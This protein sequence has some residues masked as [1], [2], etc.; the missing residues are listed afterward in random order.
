MFR[1]GRSEESPLYSVAVDAVGFFDFQL[2]PSLSKVCTSMVRSNLV[3]SV[4][5]I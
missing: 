2:L 4:S 1:D 3:L 5:I